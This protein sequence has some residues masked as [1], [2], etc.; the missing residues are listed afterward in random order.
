ML[1][2]YYLMD[3]EWLMAAAVTVDAGA[4]PKKTAIL[5]ITFFMA[6]TTAVFSIIIKRSAFHYDA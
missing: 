2:E 1:Q 5:D 6:Q 4:V 3:T